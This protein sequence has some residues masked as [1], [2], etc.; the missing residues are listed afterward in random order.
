M[1]PR[2]GA[3]SVQGT[4]LRVTRL[5]LDGSID[6]DYPVL[7]TNGFMTASFSHEYEDGEEINE[8]AADGSVCVSWKADDTLTRLSFSLSLCSPDP[9]VAA[10]IAGGNLVRN[11]DDEVI[12]YTSPPVGSVAGNPVAVELWSIANVGGKPAAGQPYWHWVFPYVKVRYDGDREFS[13]GMLS[14]EFTGQALGNSALAADGLNPVNLNDDFVTYK[15]ALVNPFTYVRTATQPDTQLF[16]DVFP[17]QP[18]DIDPD[19]MVEES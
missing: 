16:S 6:E 17:V 14:N 2:D 15:A 4:K 13:S 9:E 11:N 12:G 10:L 18:G 19:G 8:R 1:A 5:T 7:V 3:S